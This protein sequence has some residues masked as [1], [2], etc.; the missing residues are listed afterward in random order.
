MR[1]SFKENLLDC[2]QY[3]KATPNH[4]FHT[5]VIEMSVKKQEVPSGSQVFKFGPDNIKLDFLIR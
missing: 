5:L 3:K 1:F 4:T 2:I